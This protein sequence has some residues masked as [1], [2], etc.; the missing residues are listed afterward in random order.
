MN[1]LI[2]FVR[3]DVTMLSPVQQEHVIRKFLPSE[4]IPSGWSCQKKS[5]IENVQSLYE[6][7]NK[8]IQMYGSPEDLEKCI[9]NF[10]S[11]PGNQQFFQFNDSACYKTRVFVYES[12]RSM[13]YIY[14][15]DMYDLLF[16]YISEFD[17]L[18]PLQKLAYNLISFYLRTLKSK[19]AP[20]HEMIAFN[21]RFMNS[22]VT[23]KLHFEFMMA[24]NHWDKYQTRFPFDPKVRDQVL[25]CITRSFAQFDVEVK[26]GSVLKKMISKVV[27]DVPV[28]ENVSEYKKMLTW[29]DISIKKFDDMIN[30][31][32]M[33]FLARSETVDSIPTSRIRSNKIQEVPTLTLFYV[34]FVFDGTTGLANILLTIAAFI[35]LLDNG[36]H[37]DSH[38]ILLFSA[39]WTT[40][41]IITTRVVLA[42]IISFDRLF[43]VFLPILYRNYRQS[44]S[45]FLLVLLTCSLWPVFIHVILFS[46]CQF[47]F[48]IP[49]GCITIGCLTNSCFNSI[50]YSVDTLLHIV[51]STN[52]LLL[53]LKL[54]TWNNCK[55]SSKSKDLERAN[56]LAIFDAVIIILFDVIPSRIHP[57]KFSFIAI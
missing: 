31:N 18:E 22:L 41:I 39:V 17:T 9:M 20:S 53:A 11:F 42:V 43:A 8:R 28:N 56:Q 37:L 36:N 24:D 40:Y 15:K 27:N 1:Q 34:R 12:L 48:D 14:K 35:K 38:R 33:M 54:Y 6:T 3:P 55:K 32:K 10:M 50:A 2:S 19:M 29:I 26:I 7:S 23:D 16:E 21:P 30:E 49:S 45:N 13:S 46:Y 52:S 4:L 5:L 51:I 44:L 57:L 47:S 25:D